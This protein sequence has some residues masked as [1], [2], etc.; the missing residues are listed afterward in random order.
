MPNHPLFEKA[1]AAQWTAPLSE[2][3]PELRRRAFRI[4]KVKTDEDR[5]TD[6]DWAWI[7]LPRG[8]VISA[9]I[10]GDMDFRTELRIARAD[11]ITDEKQQAKWD[12]EVGV[13][14]KH[15]SVI[16]TDGTVTC[17]KN[18]REYMEQPRHANDTG[19]TATRFIELRLGEV[20]PG[21]ASCRDCEREG[22]LTIITW[23]P[24]GGVDKQEC[25]SHRAR[26]AGAR[27]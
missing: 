19:K 25:D 13:F 12:H 27:R 6:K 1:G 22:R 21:K 17:E 10:R 16:G 24:M 5:K 9:R 23:W 20:Q 4:A 26:F 18:G 7:V 2:L 15:F 8:A 11:P 3:L 14:L